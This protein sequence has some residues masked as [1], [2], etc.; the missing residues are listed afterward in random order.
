MADELPEAPTP[1]GPVGRS[2]WNVVGRIY[3]ALTSAAQPIVPLTVATPERLPVHTC[4]FSLVAADSRA[5]TPVTVTINASEILVVDSKGIR[6]AV[7]KDHFVDSGRT[8]IIEAFR[9]VEAL[10]GYAKYLQVPILKR[11]L[12]CVVDPREPTAVGYIE[13]DLGELEKQLK[14][15]QGDAEAE[16]FASRRSPSPARIATTPAKAPMPKPVRGGVHPSQL[17]SD[18]QPVA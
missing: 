6:T 10:W 15:N 4:S 14:Q 16:E 8:K 5:T 9:R 1:V 18:I 11:I 3:D 17:G 12:D 13:R 2:R 7:L